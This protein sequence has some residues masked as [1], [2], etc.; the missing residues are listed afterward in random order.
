MDAMLFGISL[1]LIYAIWYGVWRK[2]ALDMHRD[3]L[4]DLRDEIKAYFLEKNLGTEHPLYEP[5]RGL[6]NAHIRYTEKLTFRLFIAES[7]VI[8]THPERLKKLKAEVD[9]RFATHDQ[10]LKAFIKQTRTK[11][12]AILN[13]HMVESSFVFLLMMPFI[14][15]VVGM[16]KLF[17]FFKAIAENK[18]TKRIIANAK[19]ALKLAPLA[20]LI[21][22]MP[23]RAGFLHPS[24][25][26]NVV[27]E[28]S[29]QAAHQ[30]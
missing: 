6:I 30:P 17:L 28:Y 27:E 11:S 2:T 18:N 15:I 29:Y 25:N 9:A 20:G 23:A 14:F 13:A 12:I 1:L 24:I 4:F 5:L 19:H 26:S 10:E 22:A 16:I 3:E 21:L 8:S 7:I